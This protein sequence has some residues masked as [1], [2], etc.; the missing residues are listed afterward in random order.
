MVVWLAI[1]ELVHSEGTKQLYNDAGLYA[2]TPP[3]SVT[4]DIYYWSATGGP[5][6]NA[7][8]SATNAPEGRLVAQAVVSTHW[9]GWGIFNVA[10]N[11]PSQTVAVDYSDY[12]GG[13]LRFWLWSQDELEVQIEYLTG[14]GSAQDQKVTQVIPST[15]GQW[16]E[17]VI[18][19]DAFPS[20]PT[21][22]GGLNLQQIIGPFLISTSTGSGAT[23]APKNWYVDDARVTKPFS[24]LAIHPPITQVNPGQHRQFTI[25]GVSS[26]GEP[27][28]VYGGFSVS[29]NVGGLNVSAPSLA[30][31]SVLTANHTSGSI[32]VMATNATSPVTATANVQITSAN[33]QREFGVV[34]DTRTNLNLDVD[35]KL[36]A[37]FGGSA[38][39]APVITNNI[40]DRVEGFSSV[41]TTVNQISADSFSGWTVQWGL[42]GSADTNTTDMSWFYDGFIRFALKAP[43]ALQTNFVVGIRSGNVPASTELSKVPLAGYATF[44]NQW[45]EVAIPIKIFA[46]SR[47]WAD[48]SRTKNFFTITVV[49]NTGQQT[50]LID[51]VRW[52]TGINATNAGLR[53]VNAFRQG[54][55]FHLNFAGPPGFAFTLQSTTNFSSWTNILQD[56][57]SDSPYSFVHSNALRNARTLYRLLGTP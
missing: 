32:T 21:F 23:T 30:S 26:N 25:E 35:S 51:N 4:M 42:A 52:D 16:S 57:L 46:G 24:Q 28:L 38:S 10:S 15:Q 41:Q 47:P 7:T 29:T 22:P 31:S 13:A 44:D 48:L 49:G 19:F 56:V 3:G 33:L 6:I 14:D 40:Y 8:V 39:S 18:P 17:I 55:D 43:A 1:A 12:A 54:A 11:N 9:G 36:L 53:I 45:H 34:S 5:V 2:G 37:F 20:Y 27:V 50:F